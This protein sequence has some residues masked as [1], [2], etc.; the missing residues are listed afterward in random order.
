MD[1]EQQKIFMGKLNKLCDENNVNIIFGC[2]CCRAG[3]YYK[4]KDGICKEFDPEMVEK[5]YKK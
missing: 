3:L 2:G 5:V 1:M 4:E